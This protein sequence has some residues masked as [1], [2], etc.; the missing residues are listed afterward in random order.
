MSL[1]LSLGSKLQN[2]RIQ[3]LENR[4][5]SAQEHPLIELMAYWERAQHLRVAITDTRTSRTIETEY[6]IVPKRL[7]GYVKEGEPYGIYAGDM[8]FVSDRT[9]FKFA[10]IVAF[11]LF[12]ERMLGSAI[13]RTGLARHL[14]AAIDSVRLASMMDLTVPE[15]REF[16]DV[17]VRNDPTGV[18]QMDPAV[19]KYINLPSWEIP[20]KAAYLDAHGA[21]WRVRHSQAFGSILAG[22]RSAHSCFRD[23]S[24]SK[25]DVLLPKIEHV[26][27][28]LLGHFIRRAS[29][30][31]FGM[32]FEIDKTLSAPAYALTREACGFDL[33]RFVENRNLATGCNEVFRSDGEH[34]V[35]MTWQSLVTRVESRLLKL[36]REIDTRCKG[37][38]GKV[39]S[40]TLELERKRDEVKGLLSAAGQE[41][42]ENALAETIPLSQE[43]SELMAR[44]QTAF[45]G[46]GEELSRLTGLK[47]SLGA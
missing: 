38:E 23:F 9:P 44:A 8:T 40:I 3:R 37:I 33:I 41:A 34:R 26:N 25:A 11:K 6:V 2:K 22:E 24:V 4:L 46:L 39:C 14:R 15:M 1:E 30:M 47:K 19:Q 7:M 32:R 36:E 16:I 5:E 35:G 28:Y 17:L 10:P 45:H 43:A 20:E 27:Q 13:D 12:E 29:A 21:N 42:S 31:P 18:I